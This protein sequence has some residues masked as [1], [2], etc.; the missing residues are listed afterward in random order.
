MEQPQRLNARNELIGFSTKLQHAANAVTDDSRL[1]DI[2]GTLTEV[3]DGLKSWRESYLDERPVTA[4]P[5]AKGNTM[6]ADKR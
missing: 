1:Q 3:Q 2:D 4:K 5:A 6:H